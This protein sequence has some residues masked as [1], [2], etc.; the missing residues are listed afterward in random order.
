MTNP[1]SVTSIVA[2]LDDVEM[3]LI[4]GVLLATHKMETQEELI[5][6]TGRV[7]ELRRKLGDPHDPMLMESEQQSA[8]LAKASA[9][10]VKEEMKRLIPIVRLWKSDL[11]S[12]GKA[13]LY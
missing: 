13:T 1:K 6:M 8:K 3:S 2:L 11:R 4:D 12:R 7:L 5:H 10:A 9:S